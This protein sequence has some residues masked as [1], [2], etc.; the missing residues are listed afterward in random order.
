MTVGKSIK[1]SYGMIEIRGVT[2]KQMEMLDIMWAIDDLKEL[3]AWM[4]TLSVADRSQAVLLQEMIEL[5]ALDEL[6]SDVMSDP[7]I[8]HAYTNMCNGLQI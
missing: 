2:L 3:H 8:Q 1:E 5:A 6:F 7:H 4:D